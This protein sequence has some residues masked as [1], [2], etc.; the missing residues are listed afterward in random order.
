[1]QQYKNLR[2][3]GEAYIAEKQALGLKFTKNAQMMKRFL[4]FAEENDYKTPELSKEL[5]A[6]W[7][8]KTPNETENNRQHRVSF[9]RGLAEYMI[10]MGY[11][12][13]VMPHKTSSYQRNY[14]PYIF[15]NEEL[16]RIFKVSESLKDS[17][18]YPYFSCQISTMFK[19][20]YSTGMR[21]SEVLF[22]KKENVDLC[23]GRLKVTGAKFNKERYIPLDRT[24]RRLLQDYTKQMTCYSQWNNSD[25]FF[26]N[27][28]GD[29]HKDIYHSFRQ[30]LKSA[31][32]SHGG[33]GK[34]PRVHDLRHTY[35]VHVLRKWVREGR[36]FTTALPYLSAYM[37]HA[38]IRSSQYYL[39]LT[40]ELYPDII[41]SLEQNYGWLI[42]EVHDYET[43]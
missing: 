18:K 8:T 43:D 36:D 30:V 15:T 37:G 31:G 5:S 20:L 12:A 7:C 1:M 4:K 32:I 35:A 40:S 13:Y 17:N 2:E 21:T 9:L 19:L 23:T 25:F 10:R 26:V 24:M 28:N 39:R 14:Q 29:R 34:G 38:G 27:S 11:Q 3:I 22:L 42:P 16:S 6:L 33:R 41:A